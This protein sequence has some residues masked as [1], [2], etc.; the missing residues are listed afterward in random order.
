MHYLLFFMLLI[1]FSV[2]AEKAKNQFDDN[3]VNVHVNQDHPVTFA[4]KRS[5]HNAV[6]GAPMAMMYPGD[7]AGVFLGALLIHGLVNSGA[8]QV[9]KSREQAELDKVLIPFDEHIAEFDSNYFLSRAGAVND[10]EP[11]KNVDLLIGEKQSSA[12][13][14]D[15][16]ITP[17]YAMTQTKKSF[18]VLNTLTFSDRSLSGREARRAKQLAKKRKSHDRDPNKQT[19]VIVSDPIAEENMDNYWLSENA[20]VFRD[21][22]NQFY[23]ESL[24]MGLAR[25]YGH[26]K[27]SDDKQK[28]IRYLEDGVKKIERGYVVSE[29]CRRTLFE[30][31][32]G[33]LKSV[34]NL[35]FFECPSVSLNDSIGI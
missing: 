1:P 12:S 6:D 17:V 35:G 8:S 27:A 3:L 25:H 18:I 30:T 5:I 4:G 34:P 21:S 10:V 7:S 9:K 31:L 33:E 22:V 23:K 24:R 2:S 14:W 16:T 13:R 28:T 15:M 29:D 19:V 20:Q 11:I 32:A 26:L